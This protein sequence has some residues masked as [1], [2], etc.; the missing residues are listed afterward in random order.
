[1]RRLFGAFCYSRRLPSALQTRLA[2]W[3]EA[4]QLVGT[5]QL[6]GLLRQKRLS[7]GI[8]LTQLAR[9]TGISRKMLRKYEAGQRIP[10]A[11]VVARLSSVLDGAG[12]KS[13][14]VVY[15]PGR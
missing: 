2:Q 10:P 12:R 15:Q 3:I 9:V 6:I 14:F 1:L 11:E 8:S 7:A 13:G 5:G 4:E